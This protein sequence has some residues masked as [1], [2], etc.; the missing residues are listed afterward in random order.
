MALIKG[1]Q[2]ADSTV[3]ASKIAD[4]AITTDKIADANITAAKLNTSAGQTYD[5]SSATIQAGTPSNSNDVATKAY[6]DALGSTGLEVKESVRALD[7]GT[8]FDSAFTYSSGVLSEV[9]PN[10]TSLTVDGVTLS[11][12]DRILLTGRSTASQN[13]IYTF[14]QAGNGSSTAMQLTRA[15]DFDASGDISAN[16][17]FF[18][19]EGTSYGDSGWVLTADEDIVLDT[20]NLTF[21]QFSGAGQI[22][23]GNGIE[24][25]GNTLSAKIDPGY[26][27]LKVDSNGIGLDF[28]NNLS[29][30]TTFS[31]TSSTLAVQHSGN[32]YRGTFNGVVRT[33]LTSSNG[34]A[35]SA[36]LIS[37]NLSSTGGLE[38]SST[39]FRIKLD[40]VS[41][42]TDSNGLSVNLN[43]ENSI[44]LTSSGLVAPVSRT[45]R[46]SLTPTAVSGSTAAST[47][48]AIPSGITVPAG[49]A[50]QVFVNGI[51]ANLGASTTT[52]QCFFSDDSGSTAKAIDSIDAADVLYWNAS[53]TGSY[54]LETTDVLDIVY[55]SVSA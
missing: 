53:A 11:V 34:F 25:T 26:K 19:E 51:K 22:T 3:I 49:S 30:A 16:N 48:A 54:D 10:L 42:A 8:V 2:L 17:F 40:G 28:I 36:G 35:S 39:L 37:L 18:V 38:L 31:P 6:V 21:Q 1:K 45:N 29:S 9:S 7:N 33:V 50:V 47:G 41:L 20:T 24:K 46:M 15:L 14:S 4:G 27:G 52:S 5:F 55:A 13:G 12:G 43:S 32:Y 23:A 44:G